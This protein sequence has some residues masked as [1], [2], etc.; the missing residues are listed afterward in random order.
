MTK[1]PCQT[2]PFPLKVPLYSYMRECSLEQ[3]WDKT[4]F[5]IVYNDLNILDE[6][7]TEEKH[8]C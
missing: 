5:C 4:F 3:S 1:F 8:A 6:T 2:T 7:I